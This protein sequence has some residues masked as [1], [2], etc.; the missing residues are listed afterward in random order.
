MTSTVPCFAHLHRRLCCGA[1]QVES[2]VEFRRAFAIEV[3]LVTSGQIL[4]L[5]TPDEINIQ[6]VRIELARTSQILV[7]IRRVWQKLQL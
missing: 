2:V 1:L 4:T 6:R 3:C 7:E 5:Q